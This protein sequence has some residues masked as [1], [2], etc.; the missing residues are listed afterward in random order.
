[1][2]KI[3]QAGPDCVISSASI[4]SHVHVGANCVLS[5][6]CIIKEN[7][8]ILPGTI[9]PEAMVV[10]AGMV[11][12]GRPARICGEVGE[13]WGASTNGPDNEWVEGG[14]LRALVRSFK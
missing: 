12:G 14:D 13:G 4:G 9:I 6:L 3:E 10:P 1:M 5:P 7:C 8:K 2:T 11:V